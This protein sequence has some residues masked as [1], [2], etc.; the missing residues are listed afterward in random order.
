MVFFLLL[1]VA[2]AGCNDSLAPALDALRQNDPAKAKLVLA[3]LQEQCA[4]SSS[5]YE[6][7]GAANGMS[8]DS[9]A[10]ESAFKAA[11]SLEPKSSRLQAELGAAY[12]RNKKPQ[13]AAEAL[14]QA[15]ALDPSN[16]AARKY[17]LGSYIEL[18]DWSHA[19]AVFERMGAEKQPGALRDPILV[20]W[21]AQT[22]I[23]T[24]R[25]RQIDRLLAPD[26]PVMTPPLLFSLGTLFAE[27]R[28]YSTA[29]KYLRAIP[30]DKADD[31]VHFNL[32]LAYSHLREFEKARKCYFEAIDQ[33]PGH[34]SAYFRVGLDYASEGNT[35]KSIPWLLRAHS[36]EPGNAEIAYA[37][38][39]QLLQ[40][41]YIDTA[42]E[43]LKQAAAGNPSHVLLMVAAGDIQQARGDTAAAIE[44]YKKA[45]ARQPTLTPALVAIAR[46]Y[47]KQGNDADA[48]IALNTALSKDPSD[49][50]ANA[51]LG[52]LEARQEDWNAA[53]EHLEKAW[54]QDHSN[55][56]VALALAR[57]Y[58][59]INRTADA[60]GLLLPLRPALQDSSA[61]HLQLAQL[62]T[63]LK[64]PADAQ[65]ERE[66]LTAIQEQT[67]KEFHFENPKTYIY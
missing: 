45:L 64:R 42:A 8:G 16:D 61:F 9:T 31:A 57:A 5:Y 41:Q 59:H 19:Y 10:A 49:P 29:V 11:V 40:L 60:V 24:D 14:A 15:L 4:Q 52:L 67:Q 34:V 48:R 51:E 6:L 33:H 28:M 43:I 32:G 55:T 47:V 12:L 13:L 20:L 50:P 23:E 30:E 7:L 21:L 37:L 58:G 3:P 1:A 35:R 53:V 27:H 26:Q 65:A 18:K 46:A 38:A 2:T 25:G 44:T 56:W 17:L 22:L 54:T 66:A 63:Q 36:S 39:E 62:Y